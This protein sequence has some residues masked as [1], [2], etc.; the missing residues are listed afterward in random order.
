MRSIIH[1]ST[2]LVLLAPLCSL[3]QHSAQPAEEEHRY[4]FTV[5]GELSLEHEKILLEAMLGFDPRMHVNMERPD[6]LMK[7]LAYQPIEP[8]SIVELAARFGVALEQRPVR[9]HAPPLTVSDKD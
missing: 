7:V 3:A 9:G 2:F 5:Q 6:A 1:L 8:R 4:H